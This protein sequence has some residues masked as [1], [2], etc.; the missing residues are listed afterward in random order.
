M[1]EGRVSP[2]AYAETEIVGMFCTCSIGSSIFEL[3]V[4]VWPFAV[5]D[6]GISRVRLGDIRGSHVQQQ[7]GLDIGP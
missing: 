7:K 2:K 5:N 6:A 1:I 3:H 4:C